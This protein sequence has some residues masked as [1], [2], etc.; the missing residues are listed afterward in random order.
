MALFPDSP[1]FDQED[2]SIQQVMSKTYDQYI[3]TNQ[4]YWGEARTDTL[5]EAGDQNVWSDYYGNVPAYTRRTFNFNRMRR[6]GNMIQGHQRRTRK[7]ITAIPIENADQQTADQ[8]TKILMWNSQQNNLDQIISNTFYHGAVVT[9]LNLLQLWIDYSSDPLSGDIKVSQCHYNSFLIDPYFKEADLSDCSS[10]WK[11]SYVTKNQAIA[12]NPEYKDM[13]LSM[14][15]NSMRDGKFYFMPESVNYSTNNLLTYDEFWYQSFREQQLLVD[16]QTGE[17]ME[18]NST[19]DQKLKQFLSIWPQV[20]LMSQT[21]PTV[22]LAIVLQGKLLYNGRNPLNIDSYPFVPIFGYYNPQIEYYPLRVQGVMRGLR[23]A[24]YLYNRRRVIE[25]DILES[26]INSGWKYKVNALVDPRDVFMSGQGKGLAL[27]S[28][29][30]MADAEKIQPPQVPPSMIQLS[31]LLAKEVMEISGVNEEL[32]GSASDDK[33]GI[34]SMLRQGAGLTTLQVLFDNLDRSMK[35]LGQRMIKAIQNNFTPGKVKRII[36]EEPSDQFYN[37]NFGKYDCAIEEGFN[38]TTQKQLQFAQLIQLKQMGIP[39]PDE[40]LIKSAT[41]Q[42]KT[43]LIESITQSQQQAAQLQQAQAQAQIQE[44]Q[45]RSQLAQARAV[46]DHG[47]GIERLSRVDENRALAI[48]RVAQSQE[49]RANARRDNDQALLNFIKALKEI[50]T[51]DLQNLEKLITL[52]RAMEATESE[53]ANPLE[54]LKGVQ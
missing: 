50:E 54:L 17:V 47:L 16:T 10:I 37:K 36:N 52:A 9:G 35:I 33:A 1:F 4:A 3:T 26:Q 49:N 38:T 43:E 25:L 7:S 21:I 34:L 22:N 31:E 41:L 2:R 6:I 23:D 11:R 45:S 46:A 42:N 28:E 44:L 48:E 29:A 40:T 24:Q 5:F 15:G 32:L 30:S 53:A 39:I 51:I 8:L 19:D 14:T 20:K 13:I 18:W 12:L 27:K